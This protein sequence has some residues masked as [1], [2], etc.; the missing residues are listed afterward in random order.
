M[1]RECRN[2]L[3]YATLLFVCKKPFIAAVNAYCTK[4]C[5]DKDRK[6]SHRKH[7]LSAGQTKGCLLYTS[8]A[9]DE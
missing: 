6:H 3:F 2:R 9:A 5:C 7:Y 8:D 1:C 4:G